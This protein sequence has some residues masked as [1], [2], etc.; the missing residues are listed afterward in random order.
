MRWNHPMSF[1]SGYLPVLCS[2]LSLSSFQLSVPW[3]SE[4]GAFSIRARLLAYYKCGRGNGGMGL[5]GGWPFSRPKNAPEKRGKEE[6]EAPF[7]SWLLRWRRACSL[8]PCTNENRTRGEKR[9]TKN[10]YTRSWGE[11]FLEVFF[12]TVLCV[13]RIRL[14]THAKSHVNFFLVLLVIAQILFGNLLGVM[15]H[16]N[17][18]NRMSKRSSV[19]LPRILLLFVTARFGS[20]M[21]LP[22]ISL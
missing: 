14:H 6:K 10:I 5:C 9:R 12:F 11:R 21:G 3:E 7:R 4:R 19:G 16:P 1:F 22:G 20:G 18:S 15:S 2:N 8:V 17:G 13:L